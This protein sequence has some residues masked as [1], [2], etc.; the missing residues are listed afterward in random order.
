M[1]AGTGVGVGAGVGVGG[2][3]LL[4]L[5]SAST[6]CEPIVTFRKV[7]GLASA[8]PEAVTSYTPAPSRRVYPPL[9]QVSM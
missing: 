7:I 4:G 8:P 6:F 9:D 1:G 2:V 3:G 5:K